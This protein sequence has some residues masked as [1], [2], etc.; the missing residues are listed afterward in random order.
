M[1]VELAVKEAHP[2]QLPEIVALPIVAGLPAYLN[3]IAE[4]TKKDINV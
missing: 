4:E 3:W 1:E 2:Y